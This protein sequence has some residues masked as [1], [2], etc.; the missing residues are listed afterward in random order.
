MVGTVLLAAWQAGGLGWQCRG[1]CMLR[2]G[3]GLGLSWIEA[4][5][6][7]ASEGS[8]SD[9]DRALGCAESAELGGLF[10]SEAEGRSLCACMHLAAMQ[11][12]CSSMLMGK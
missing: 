4:L 11:Q 2:R 3:R 10:G 12:P 1:C 5:C 9:L 6:H 7:A 8:M